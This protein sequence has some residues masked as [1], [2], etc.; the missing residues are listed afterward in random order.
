VAR[1]KTA[2]PQALIVWTTGTQ[3]STVLRGMR[4]GGLDLPVMASSGNMNYAL[5][6]GMANVMPSELLFPGMRATKP[7]GT[8]PGPIKQA[9]ATFYRTFAELGFKPDYA[10]IATWDSMMIVIEALRALGPDAQAPQVRDWIAKS[11]GYAGINGIYD[12]RDGSQRGIGQLGALILRWDPAKK[13]Y[14]IESKPGGSL[15]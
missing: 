13:D 8:A 5:L 2:K 10:N 15:R 3:F 14:S 6:D 7:E 12:Y 4:D 1:L 11:H 9:Q